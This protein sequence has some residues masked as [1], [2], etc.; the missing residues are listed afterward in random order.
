M[1]CWVPFELNQSS[2]LPQT[3]NMSLVTHIEISLIHVLNDI[4]S[5][6]YIDTGFTIDTDS[7]IFIQYVCQ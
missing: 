1:L 4:I 6:S 3:C 2:V 5:A 7:N